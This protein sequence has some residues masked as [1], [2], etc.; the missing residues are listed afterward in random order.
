[1]L[2][3]CCTMWLFRVFFC[4]LSAQQI[5]SFIFYCIDLKS[6]LPFLGRLLAALE[7]REH[8][9]EQLKVMFKKRTLH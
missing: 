5:S 6:S 8:L 7:G 9:K 2:V 3:T 4:Y 1:M